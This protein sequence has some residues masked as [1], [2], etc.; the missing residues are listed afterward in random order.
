MPLDD[1]PL[2]PVEISASSLR[3]RLAQTRAMSL[4][5]AE[6]LTEEDQIVQAMEDASPTKW[7]LAH[8][9]W[10]FEEFVLKPYD[11]AYKVFDERFNYCFNS[12]YEN[13]GPRHPRPKRSLL[14]R[15]AHS[16]VLSY[17]HH[18]DRAL[19]NFFDRGGNG[20]APEALALIELGINHEQ[21]HQELMFT[22]CL[23]L[24]AGNPLR[25]AYRAAEVEDGGKAAQDVQ[26]IDFPGGIFDIGHDAEEGGFFYDNEGPRHQQLIRPFRLANRLVTNGE[27]LE[28]MKAG[29]YATATLWLSDGWATV[30][31]E[32]W[33]APLY[34]EQRDGAWH[35]MTLRG[36][37][38]VALSRPVTHISFY[39]ADAFAR[40][41]G[42]RLPTEF[43]WEVAAE[44]LEVEGNMLGT[45]RLLPDQ[46]KRGT[47]GL[48]Q[49]FGDLWEWTGSAYSPYPGFKTAPG[50]VGEYNGKFM[51]NQ[52]VLRGGS[53]VTPE[54]HVR[55]TYRN[56]FYPHHR[57]QFMGMRLADDGA[58]TP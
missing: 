7:H 25:P 10:F 3:G 9:T 18:I 6:P 16:E 46:A 26:W 22:D 15:P 55:R 44:S 23:A 40:W 27:W 5:I 42:K 30:N 20:P 14:T 39:E 54:G 52:F 53:C 32:G 33:E 2:T 17:R 1:F 4:R 8:T 47:G 37:L 36:L 43:E 45:D 35:E 12:Y 28:F 19:D 56:F 49:M 50:A 57:W 13:A 41:A 38:P 48:Q 31:R 21:Q 58:V 51:C 11:R 29:G 34:W 24:F